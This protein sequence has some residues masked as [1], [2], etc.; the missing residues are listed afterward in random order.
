MNDE[1]IKRIN[2]VLK[3]IDDNLDKDLSLE[4]LSAIACYSP[5]HL[6]RLFKAYTNETLNSFI[7]RKRIEKTASVLIHKKEITITELALSYGFNSNSSFTRAFKKSYGVSPSE[8]KRLSI[9]TYSKIGKVQSKNGQVRPTFEDYICNMNHHNRWIE[10]NAKIEIKEIEK[11]DLAFLT[12]IGVS[13][14]HN[15]FDKLVKWAKPKGLFEN[16][17]V[18]MAR[19]Y[20]DSFKI[21]EPEKVRMSACVVL[22]EPIEVSGEIGLTVIEKG[23]CIVGHF[24]IEPKDFGKSW[25][26]LFVWMNE[27]GFKKADKNPF[28]IFHNNFRE[29]PENKSIVDFYIPVL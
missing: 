25:K 13:G 12:Q 1:Y 15:A 28:E 14:L 17:N 9:N 24:E 26:A 23:K 2:K 7:T 16:P 29:H 21:T 6:H 10:M 19:I 4:K 3:Y 20:H 11:L 22:N 8:F 18:K 5:F 27:N